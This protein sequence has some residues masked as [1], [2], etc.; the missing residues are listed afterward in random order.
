MEIGNVCICGGGSLGSVIAG[1]LASP[2]IEVAYSPVAPSGGAA[3][4]SDR[5]GGPAVRGAPVE[6]IL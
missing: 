2:G 6:G 3:A 5:P 1:V 4:S